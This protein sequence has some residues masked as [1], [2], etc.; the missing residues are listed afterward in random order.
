VVSVAE[1]LS[2]GGNVVEIEIW[3][4]NGLAVAVFERCQ[5][6]IGVGMGGVMFQGFAAVEVEAACRMAAVP[7]E[8]LDDVSEDVQY[9]GRVVA[10]RHN[11]DAV[12]K[13]SRS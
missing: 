5:Q 8:R 13:R 3:S 9:M 7:A 11:A 10:H 2:D 12:R 1:F 6:S 4:C